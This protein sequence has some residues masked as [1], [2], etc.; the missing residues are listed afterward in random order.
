MEKQSNARDV[1]ARWLQEY[2]GRPTFR[3][4][5]A[6]PG[7][8]F[9]IVIPPPNVTGV[10]HIGHALNNTIQDLVIRRRRMAGRKAL[11]IPGTDHAGIATQNVVERNLLE[12]GQRRDDLGREK[13]LEEVWKWKE[14]RGGTIIEQLKRLGCSCDWSRERFTM[15]PGLS[16]AVRTCF[17]RLYQRGLIYRG[18]YIVNW[19]PRCG[20]A[21]ANEEVEHSPEESHLY[22]VRYPGLDGGP[23]VVVATTRPETLFGDTAVAVNPRDPRYRAL[24]G[25]EV[26]LPILG[27]PIPVVAHPLVEK[28]FG[29]GAVK[30]T[31]HHD[32][33]D[34]RIGRDLGL[35]G[36]TVIDE[37]GFLNAAA[38]PFAG[39]ERFAAREGVVACLKEDGLLEKV[40]DYHHSVGRCYRCE[41]VV[42]PYLS[43]QWFVRMKSLAAPALE[44]ARKGQPRFHPRR[45][46]K[47]YQRW[48]ENIEDWCIS[49]QLWWG[50]RL[51]VYYC[52]DCQAR[53]GSETAGVIVALE[54][55]EVCPECGRREP[56]QDPDVLDTW[57]SSWLWPFSVLGW[58]EETD[59]LKAFYPTQLLVTA[60]EIIFFWVARMA[61]AGLEFQGRLPFGEV[62][63]HGTVRDET[64]R[65]MSKSYGNVI[66]PLEVINEVGADALR[67]SLI[68]FASQGQ[69]LFIGRKSFALGRNF[70]NKIWNA[71]RLVIARAEAA[72]GVPEPDPARFSL[73]QRWILSELE[74]TRRVVERKF[75]SLRLNEVATALYQFFWHSYCDWYLEMLKVDL[76][77]NDDPQSLAVAVLVLDRFLRLLHPLMPFLTEEIWRRLKEADLVRDPAPLLARAAW[78]ANVR[79]HYRPALNRQMALL[80]ESVSA[81]RNLKREFN[82]APGQP[83]RAI[84]VLPRPYHKMIGA[85]AHYL[86]RLAGVE[87]LELETAHQRRRLEASGLLS[88]G[89]I[90]LPLAGLFDPEREIVRLN[91]ELAVLER[92][93][94]KGSGRLSSREFLE[95]APAEVIERERARQSQLREKADRI[96]EHLSFLK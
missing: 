42:E 30:V 79:G 40:E 45:W 43:R 26:R 81:V 5:A 67:F 55:P 75:D 47:V 38:G 27:R 17:R 22:H 65:K 89:E 25:K 76:D 83:V 29:T 59:D 37:R 9:T 91:K 15:D 4:E 52:P 77:E 80:L 84:L 90:Y 61:M 8:P 74:A 28:G 72:G 36:L 44:L 23:G 82:L 21:L 63:I 87:T 13:F 88:R 54:K 57:F 18:D 49:R 92:E 64:G 73:S 71:S 1:E 31:P 14:S 62:Y 53:G 46:Q 7:E 3:A 96:K 6:D 24:V 34:F 68:S 16:R 93:L 48:L 95:K 19:C 51:P 94:E 56:V 78:P 85:A 32:P 20:T 35:P 69:D 41:T 60:P 86:K 50:H 12:K 2:A 66:D 33:N 10:L 58:P 70:A 39:Q 11:W